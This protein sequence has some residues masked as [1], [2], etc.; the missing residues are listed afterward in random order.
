MHC[1]TYNGALFVATYSCHVKAI[2]GVGQQLASVVLLTDVIT[3]EN[4]FLVI[5]IPTVF[6]NILL[7][8]FLWLQFMPGPATGLRPGSGSWHQ[9]YRAARGSPGIC[10]F[11]FLSNFNE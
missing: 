1:H 10:H 4:Q 9:L 6:E 11:S 2:F 8:A 3:Y 7:L 5:D